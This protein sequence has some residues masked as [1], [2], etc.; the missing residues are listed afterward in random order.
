MAGILFIVP[1]PVGNLED[2]TLRAVR[3]LKEADLI[4]AEDTRTTS[5][6]LKHFDIHRPLQSHHKYNEHQTVELVK[7]RILGVPSDVLER[8]GAVSRE[9]A[10]A[11]AAGV[12][13]RTGADLAVSVTGICG[14]GT[15][16]RNT[17]VGTGFVG[18]AGPD[19]LV[20]RPI[21]MGADRE[22]GRVVAASHAFDLL[23]RWLTGTLQET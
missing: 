6:L 20:C 11:M 23:R 13:E 17:P 16:E 3:V 7:E 5:V 14:P 18:F 8:F 9:T 21:Q 10:L 1:T 2:M 12:R 19:R 22:R 15:D 4:L